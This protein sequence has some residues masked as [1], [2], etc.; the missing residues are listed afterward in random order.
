MFLLY[1]NDI[2]KYIE[3]P[4][5]LFTDDF[6]LY[7]TIKTHEDATKFQQDLDLLHEWAVK[8]QLRF[9]VTKCTIMLFTRTLSS[10][11][12]KLNDNNLGKHS[13][14]SITQDNNLL[15]S[16]H[17]NNTATKANTV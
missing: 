2:T 8:W 11:N 13:Y 7:R 15:W 10:I 5:R 1:I 3:S 4:L 17:I 6:I 16:S 9:N 14:L 12:Y